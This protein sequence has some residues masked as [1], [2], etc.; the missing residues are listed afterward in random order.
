MKNAAADLKSFLS[1]RKISLRL[2]QSLLTRDE[3]GSIGKG[4]RALDSA[5]AAVLAGHRRSYAS[6]PPAWLTAAGSAPSLVPAR[7]FR[8]GSRGG[9][10]IDPASLRLQDDLNELTDRT[11]STRRPSDEMSHVL[12][13]G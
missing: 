7:Q 6:L 9:N 5:V 12:Y 1:T 2:G 13:L 10:E 8:R 4:R 11:S 3:D